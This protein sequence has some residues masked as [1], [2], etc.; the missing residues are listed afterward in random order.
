MWRETT[1]R[2]L[3]LMISC[4]VWTSIRSK[5]TTM[6]GF[7]SAGV[8][9]L[10]KT[11]DEG[12]SDDESGDV[13]FAMFLEPHEEPPTSKRTLLRKALSFMVNRFQPSPVFTHVELVV[14]CC[15]GA[16]E[17]VNFSAYIG[18]TSNWQTDQVSNEAYYLSDNAAKWR[19][20]PVFGKHAAQRVRSV[21]NRS[22]GV[23]YSITRY[24]TSSWPMRTC[25]SM[26]PDTL[27][28]PAHCATM[29]SR[30]LNKSIGTCLRHPSAW[31]GPSTLYAELRKD[32]KDQKI[33][34]ETTLMTT[35][36][37]DAVHTMLWCSDEEVQALND[38]K[39][40]DAIRALTLKVSAAEAIG[41]ATAQRLSQ[42]QLATALFRWSVMRRPEARA[43][44]QRR[45]FTDLL[46]S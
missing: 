34:P 22:I 16:H 35:E 29:V 7:K 44:V 26:M 41:D 1:R 28:S 12:L 5:I 36:T 17:P 31:Y 10:L 18:Q 42:H 14:P 19:A 46:N 20:V 30:I 39:C 33:L 11:L 25:A 38:T 23:P 2:G 21:C 37:N 40:L 45:L 8:A 24:L 3:E 13:V 27:Q 32:L 4:T 15:A 6:I 9:R 43:T